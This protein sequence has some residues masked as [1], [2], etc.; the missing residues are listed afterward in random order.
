MKKKRIIIIAI[1]AL[2]V[3][4][5]MYYLYYGVLYKDGRVIHKEEPAFMVTSIQILKEYETNVGNANIKY[6]NKTI[7]VTG[8]ITQTDT[9]ILVL[10][11]GVSCSFDNPLG[12][13]SIGAQT[14]VKGRCLGYDELFN[15]VKMDQ[16]TIKEE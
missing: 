14:T 12:K 5:A 4:G 13:I 11:P 6:L 2:L 8:G 3:F 7:E 10:F 9:H 16:C 1:S 15:E